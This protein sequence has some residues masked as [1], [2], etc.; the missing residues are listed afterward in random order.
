MKKNIGSLSACTCS[1]SL[2]AIHEK[3][4]GSLSACT[5]SA[6][7]LAIHEKNIGSLSACT[8][9]TSLLAIHEKHIGSLSTCTCSGSFVSAL[10]HARRWQSMVCCVP[11]HI[12][13]HT[14][15]I[16]NLHGP[17]CQSKMLVVLRKPQE[18]YATYE[19]VQLS[20]SKQL[21]KGRLLIL[22]VWS[23]QQLVGDFQCFRSRFTSVP[24]VRE[25][26][27]VDNYR[28]HAKSDPLV[29]NV[30]TWE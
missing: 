9:S 12:C 5:C 8:C 25:I 15:S 14:W 30:V 18:H 21:S 3:H 19:V 24:G 16:K 2:L 23:L 10:A 4:I 26:S 28:W 27:W 17:P 7:F 13:M 1:T 29:G 6:T 20:G 22:T 11:W